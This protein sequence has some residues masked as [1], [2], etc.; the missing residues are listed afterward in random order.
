MEKR[1]L[2]KTYEMSLL[3]GYFIFSILLNSLGNALTVS[4]NLGS[5]LW[6]AAA[7][8]VS[9]A[10]TIQLGLILFVEG[11]LVILL[12][13]ILVGRISFKR[14]IGNLLFMVSFSY[15]IGEIS[16]KLIFLG[17]DNLN[18]PLRVLL[19][20][21]GIVLI[22]TAIS[23]YQRVNLI[24]HP[25][26][27]LMQILRFKFFKGNP[28]IAQLVSF[29]P[30]IIAIIFA[31]VITGKIYAINIGTLFALFFQGALVG[32]A[33]RTVFPTLKHHNLEV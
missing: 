26:D 21:V 2:N 14:I 16:E 33:D 3:L 7:V 1:P 4:L 15:L 10:L 22:S 17:I 25:C 6:T 27:D 12:N 23:I 31:M 18:L 24:M 19:D 9:H 11:I 5:A 20:C 28:S 32:V 13:L 30:P 29:I 8:N